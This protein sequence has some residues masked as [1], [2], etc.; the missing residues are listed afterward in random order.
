MATTDLV[1]LEILVLGPVSLRRN[2]HDLTPPTPMHGRI[3]QA[4]ALAPHDTYITTVELS[5]QCSHNGRPFPRSE[6]AIHQHIR[7]VRT[8]YDDLIE[9]GE[10]G[11]H[12]YRLNRD[13][14]RVD[15]WEFITTV[16]SADIGELIAMWRP[17]VPALVG[18][19]WARVRAA[20]VRLIDRIAQLTPQ[21]Q[22]ALV[23]LERFTSIFPG[24]PEI[25]P[26]RVG[27]SDGRPR[28]LVVDDDPDV[29]LEIC[30]RLKPYYECVPITEITEW[31]HKFRDNRANLADIQG[32]LVDLHLTRSLADSRGLEIVLF[33]I[34][35][36][37]SVVRF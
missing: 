32:A 18:P 8:K 12:G 13:K 1:Q 16:D 15:A 14:C 34:I 23:G 6:N 25:D 5:R 22:A 29:N 19:R 2:G 20:R 37:L 3:L 31:R 35:F 4:L 36:I 11:T 21:D 26:I 27:G 33:L 17:E 7:A 30:E 9:T 24:D 28:L 10:R